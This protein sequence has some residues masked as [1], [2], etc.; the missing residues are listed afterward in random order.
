M[1][2]AFVQVIDPRREAQDRVGGR[3]DARVLE[4][5]PPPVAASPWFA[6]DPVNERVDPDLPV[7]APVPIPGATTTWDEIARDDPALAPW[8]ADRW[9]GAFRS[10]VLPADVDALERTRN[11]WHVLAEHVLAP[12]RHRA[13]G[14]IG[15]RFTRG[16]FGTPFFGRLEQVRVTAD[17]LVAVRAGEVEVHP[18]STA[19]DAARVVGI[20]PGAPTEV[21]TPTT[22]L[23]PDAP[24]EVDAASAQFLGDWFGYG[25]LVLEA[26][27]ASVPASADPARVQ[28]WPEHFD[29]SVDFGD[30]RTGRRATYGASPGDA[31]HPTPYLYVTPWER[32]HGEFWNEDTF[33]SSSF[34]ALA[35][36]PDQRAVALEF[37]ARAR[38]ELEP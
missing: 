5:S 25:T 32:Q 4:P 7:L 27:R 13:N 23:E 15:L 2:D 16:G 30:A 35:G 18:V 38:A 24:L 20:A 11:A 34:D 26:L 6:D 1:A 29:L 33:A 8:C 21:Y 14:K 17:G 12:A 36:Q 28:I 22:K 19:Q 37:F 10:L 3:F 31:G 9:L